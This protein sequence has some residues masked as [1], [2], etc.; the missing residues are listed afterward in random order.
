M[1]NVE[2]CSDASQAGNVGVLSK[3]TNA[4]AAHT[5]QFRGR[6]QP[7]RTETIERG[8]VLV[9]AATRPSRRREQPTESALLHPVYP[10]AVTQDLR[11]EKALG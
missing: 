3:R 4:I 5:A 2:S 1:V 11:K 10:T 7:A 8:W 9:C 6:W